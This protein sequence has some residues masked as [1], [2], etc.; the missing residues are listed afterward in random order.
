MS[1][2]RIGSAEFSPLLAPKPAAKPQGAGFL[3][4]LGKAIAEV[5]S[6]QKVG[7][8]Q[9]TQLANGGGNLHETALALEKADVSMRVMVKVR[10][11]LV[12][13]YNEVMRMS[14]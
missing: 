2:L 4:A 9:A 13:A 11:K 5:D 10:N 12:D 6:Q 7:D 8:A 3:D 14:A 1:D